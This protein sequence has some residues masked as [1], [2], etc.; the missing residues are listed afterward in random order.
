MYLNRNSITSLIRSAG[1]V[2]VR[3]GFYDLMQDWKTWYR[4]KVSK[5]HTY[6]IH[7]AKGQSNCVEMRSLGMAK[8]VCED[9]ANLLFNEKTYVTIS[10]QGLQNA[11]QAAIDFNNFDVLGNESIE[12]AFAEGTGAWVLRQVN[13]DDEPL[14]DYV[15]GD[16]IFPLEWANGQIVSCAFGSVMAKKGKMYLYL[17]SHERKRDNSKSEW[18]YVIANRFYEINVRTGWVI[19]VPVKF[20]EVEDEKRYYTATPLFSIVRP[21]IANNVDENSPMGISIYAN[22][23]DNLKDCDIAFDGMSISMKTGR[24]RIAIAEALVKIDANGNPRPITDEQDTV[25]YNIPQEFTSKDTKPLIEDITPA[26]RANDYAATLEKELI[27]LSQKVGMGDMVY[28]FDG[29][30]VATAT[31]VISENSGMFRTMQKHQKVIAMALRNLAR[32]ILFLKNLTVAKAVTITVQFDDSIIEDTNAEKAQMI[33]EINAGIAAP[34]EYRMKFY[35][36][37]EDAAKKNV[38]PPKT[39]P[40]FDFTAAGG[41]NG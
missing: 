17:Q 22:A 39:Y 9:W 8:K 41:G 5:F 23:I 26:Y 33:N 12:S 11:F 38:P 1:Y 10:E 29:T 21:A 18:Y 20:E 34:W 13:E 25:I 3:P 36:E 14:I 7:Q 6:K 24:P 2:T 32:G 16:M 15:H 35:G 31:Q 30:N 40:T 28:K 19:D 37:N 27:L 4:G